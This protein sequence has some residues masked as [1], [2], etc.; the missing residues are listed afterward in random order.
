MS[1]AVALQRA[2]ERLSIRWSSPEIGVGRIGGTDWRFAEIAPRPALVAAA[3]MLRVSAT[4]FAR[5][6][7]ASDA[8]R[9]S[10]P[11]MRQAIDNALAAP[12]A[13]MRWNTRYSEID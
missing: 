4:E 6:L 10:A 3:A 7:V 9:F 5:L 13:R 12:A 11:N 1:R 2:N 8:R